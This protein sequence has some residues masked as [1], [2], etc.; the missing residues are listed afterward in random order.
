MSRTR[1]ITGRINDP[2]QLIHSDPASPRAP[3]HASAMP[4]KSGMLCPM[5]FEEV[6]HYALDFP[7]NEVGSHDIVC[8]I[9]EYAFSRYMPYMRVDRICI[10]SQVTDPSWPTDPI[11]ELSH[12]C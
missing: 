9:V 11:P 2:M 5:P 1:G 7:A 12:F 8:L 6:M 4:F 10:L 3:K